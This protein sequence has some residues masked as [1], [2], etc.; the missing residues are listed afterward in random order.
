[1][2]DDLISVTQRSTKNRQTDRGCDARGIVIASD[3]VFDTLSGL[4]Q[5]NS[6]EWK[7]C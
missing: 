4:A 2:S 7:F 3:A 1:V 6:P 5:Q